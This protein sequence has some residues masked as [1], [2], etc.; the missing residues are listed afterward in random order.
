MVIKVHILTHFKES[1]IPK[2]RSSLG[3]MKTALNSHAFRNAIVQHAPFKTQAQLPNDT[4]HRFIL[5]GQELDSEADGVADMQLEMV[6]S[7]SPDNNVIGYTSNGVIYTFN[8]KFETLSEAALAGHYAHEYCHTIG[9]ADPVNETDLPFNV[10][11]EVGRIV[12]E[13]ALGG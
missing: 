2:L 12:T 1:H 4:I 13:I 11:Y 3:L 7:G 8:N 5:M 10:P 9:F 6:Y